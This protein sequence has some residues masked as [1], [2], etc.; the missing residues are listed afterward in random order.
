MGTKICCLCHKKNE[1]DR[2]SQVAISQKEEVE[3]GLCP[4]C[5]AETREK[6]KRIYSPVSIHMQA[7]SKLPALSEMV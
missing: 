4:S 5:F 7:T 3:H 2:W 1:S 6:V